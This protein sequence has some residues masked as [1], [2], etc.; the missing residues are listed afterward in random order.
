MKKLTQLFAMLIFAAAFYQT[1]AQVN[2]VRISIQMQALDNS[3]I[4]IF[5]DTINEGDIYQLNPATLSAPFNIAQPLYNAFVGSKFYFEQ[6]SLSEDI[7]LRFRFYGVN[8]LTGLFPPDS[9]WNSQIGPIYL[10]GFFELKVFDFQGLFPKPSPYFFNSPDNFRMTFVRTPAFN[11]LLGLIGINPM[12][13]LGLVYHLGP[14]QY[15]FSGIDSIY[16]GPD[17]ISIEMRH[18][19]KLAGGDRSVLVNSIQLSGTGLEDEN[20][21]TEFALAQNFPNPFN[22]STTINYSVSVRTPVQLKVYN[23]LGMEVATLVDEMKEAGNYSINFDASSS[24]SYIPSGIYIYE[25]RANNLVLS[26]KMIYLK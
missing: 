6:N 21:P 3:F 25:L 15:T 11:N 24:D 10:W 13:P 12:N 7:Y 4:E 23:M 22:P 9:T 20:V 5:A 17:S 18:F 14:G 19:S 16:F 1:Y 26:K 8:L 2:Q